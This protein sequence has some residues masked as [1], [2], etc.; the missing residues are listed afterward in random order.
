MR[1]F[2]DD[3]YTLSEFREKFGTQNNDAGVVI[4]GLE[5]GRKYKVWNVIFYDRLES[6]RKYEVWNVIYDGRRLYRVSGSRSVVIP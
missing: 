4:D 1:R 5:S 2:P 3:S 6:G